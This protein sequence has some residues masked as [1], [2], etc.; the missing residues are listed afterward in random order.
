MTPR[1]RVWPVLAG[2]LLVFGLCA[3]A[4]ARPS[5]G[6]KAMTYNLR[7]A[8]CDAPDSPQHWSQ[9]RLLVAALIR[10]HRPDV[11]AVQEAERAQLDDLVDLLGEY[12]WTGVGRDDGED[13]GEITA[14]LY[15][16]RRFALES[17]ATRWLSETPE[18]VSRGWDAALP[19]TL[20]MA[21]LRDADSGRRLRVFNAHFDHQ[22]E[23]ARLES[24]RL[25][26]REIAAAGASSPVLLLGDFNFTATSEG[27][28][29][30]AA[31]L[32]D[33]EAAALSP[34]Q[35]GSETLNGFGRFDGRGP[36]IDFVFVDAL[37]RVR[38]HRIDGGE[39]SQR[40]ASD[41]HPIIVEVDWP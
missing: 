20:G 9:R 18:R 37:A 38:S 32:R 41:H 28:A 40:D 35:G 10:R 13:R 1:R 34:P 17:A 29:V 25:V 3:A 16:E 21:A 24:S 39:A 33:A 31:A 26:L 12:A 8:S 27:Y 2:L 7:C 5:F 19:R 30:L 22:G 15:R 23:R 36:K 14:I 6:V 4:A 11:L